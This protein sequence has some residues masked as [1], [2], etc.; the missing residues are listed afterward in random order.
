MKSQLR[1]TSGAVSAAVA[2][3]LLS[4]LTVLAGP[5]K[6]EV[7]ITNLTRGQILSPALVV[8][9]EPG[10]SPMFTLGQPAGDEIAAIAEDAALD[11]MIAT[12][13]A[14]PKVIEIQTLTGVNGPILPGETASVQFDAGARLPIAEVSLIG[15]LV[16]TNDAFYGVSGVSQTLLP[17]FWAGPRVLEV[18]SPA[19]DAGTEANNEECAYIPGPPCGSP[20]VRMT[21][22]AEGHVHVHSG[23]YGKGDLDPAEFDWRNPVAR[24]AI[25]KVPGF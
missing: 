4:N 22:G 24:I 5:P 1:S 7:T 18:Y 23:I 13:S 21:E 8:L 12:L 20:N 9:H 14:D 16:T 11:P 25:R 19:Y 6:I 2:A 17:P 3:L 10:L 15:M